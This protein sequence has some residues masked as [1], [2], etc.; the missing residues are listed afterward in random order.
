MQASHPTMPMF[1]AFRASDR[2][3]LLAL[4]INDR[5]QFLSG[6]KAYLEGWARAD[7]L[8]EGA[9]ERLGTW[10]GMRC[11]ADVAAG[12]MNLVKDSAASAEGMAAKLRR[13]FLDGIQASGEREPMG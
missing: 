11:G 8:D 10:I 1:N 5:E 6:L 13:C 12:A 7:W 9:V 3:K 4:S 2:S